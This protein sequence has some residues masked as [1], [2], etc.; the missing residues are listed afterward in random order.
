MSENNISGINEI[1][2]ATA[3]DTEY[4]ESQ[5]QLLEGLEHVRIR[6]GMYIGSTGPKGLHHLV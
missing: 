2:G 1:S 3:T 4:D 5:I 6:P